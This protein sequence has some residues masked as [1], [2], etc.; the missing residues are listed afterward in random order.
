MDIVSA[1]GLSSASGLNAY[2]PM[3]IL[4]LLDRYTSYIDLPAAWQWLSNPWMLGIVTILL[5]VE[6]VADKIPALDSLNDIIQTVIR[7]TSGGIVFS[8]GMSSDSPMISGS[9]A[10]FAWTP[11]IIGIV[12]A[13]A[14]HV[15]KSL[16][17][18]VANVTTAGFAAPVLSAG[19]DVTS[20]GLSL[21]A[22]FIPALVI[23]ILVAFVGFIGYV[24]YRARTMRLARVDYQVGG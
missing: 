5:A 18:P 23:V 20:I 9:E 14:I 13:L 8:S 1:L 22:V 16:S 10:S 4:G 24:F 19:E 12:V 11:F 3:L 15:L 7:P 21:V 17:R 2:V 6:I